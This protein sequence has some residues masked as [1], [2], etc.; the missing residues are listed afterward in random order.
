MMF[1]VGLNGAKIP[2]KQADVHVQ[3]THEH[4]IADRVVFGRWF[5]GS[6]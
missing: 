5:A 4:H 3:P 2:D 6:S 1:G